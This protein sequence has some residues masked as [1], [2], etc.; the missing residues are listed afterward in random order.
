LDPRAWQRPCGNGRAREESNAETG[1][2]CAGVR[3]PAPTECASRSRNQLFFSVCYGSI[4]DSQPAVITIG[5][6]HGA[7]DLT[8]LAA[9]HSPDI[10]LFWQAF[11][12][13]PTY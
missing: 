2:G 5:L 6:V 9:D 8:E 1:T 3:G 13:K 7:G 10:Q 12:L 11:K 4:A